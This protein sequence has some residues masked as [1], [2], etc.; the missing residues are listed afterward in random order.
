MFEPYGYAI[1][2]LSFLIFFVVEGLLSFLSY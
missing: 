2:L 1:N